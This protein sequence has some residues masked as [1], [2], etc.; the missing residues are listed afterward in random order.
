MLKT[1]N[2][3]K[4]RVGFLLYQFVLPAIQVSLFC[5]A[6]GQD[7]KEQ[8]VAV[9]NAENFGAPCPDAVITQC[10][11]SLGSLGIPE[12]NDYLANF[13]CRYLSFIDREIAR[14]VYYPNVESAIQAVEDGE[15]WGVLAMDQNFTQD[16]YKRIFDSL[17]ESDLQAID[18]ELMEKS[19]IKVRMDITNQHIALT[20]QLK[21]AEAFQN[22][23]EQ[24][25]TSCDLPKEI[26]SIPLVFQEPIYGTKELTFTDFMAPGKWLLAALEHETLA[27]PD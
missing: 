26:A 20:L 2:R 15:A 11:I 25:V 19:S 4:K 22:F 10:P 27:K 14:P 3:M 12:P 13:T 21:F 5:L 17:T 24:M 8:P 18:T 16:L 6:I 1:F 7:P 9:V 23:L